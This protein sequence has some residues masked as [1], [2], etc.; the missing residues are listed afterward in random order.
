MS[1]TFISL[2][3]HVP[4]VS[5]CKLGKFGQASEPA[6]LCLVL[7]VDPRCILAV[8][9]LGKAV[10]SRGDEAELRL[11]ALS[12]RVRKEPRTWADAPDEKRP[13]KLTS[14]PLVPARQ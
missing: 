12:W 6:V 9:S 3:T 4:G 8:S 10:G 11:R 13:W 1:G 7:W 5:C 2:R 14:V